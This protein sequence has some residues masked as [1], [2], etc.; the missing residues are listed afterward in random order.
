MPLS[1]TIDT[2][3]R[4]A[5]LAS[6]MQQ[7]IAARSGSAIFRSAIKEPHRHISF[8]VFRRDLCAIV[9]HLT[10]VRDFTM[11]AERSRTI[12]G[13]RLATDKRVCL[14]VSLYIVEL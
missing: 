13:M 9:E 4:V 3:A 12:H 1:S 5:D 7:P 6:S 11:E 14:K 2:N 10:N 8:R